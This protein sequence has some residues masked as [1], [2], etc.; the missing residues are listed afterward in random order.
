MD[1]MVSGIKVGNVV[2]FNWRFM[3]AQIEL[4]LS[5][6]VGDRIHIVGPETDFKQIVKDME[7]ARE[8]V[9][10]GKSSQKVWIPVV[11]RVRPGD[12][13]EVLPPR[14]SSV[15]EHWITPDAAVRDHRGGS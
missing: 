7:F 15:P 12:A 11:A 3:R 10:R 14:D 2:A 13:V 1:H 6:R 5:L 8:R 4:R 9:K